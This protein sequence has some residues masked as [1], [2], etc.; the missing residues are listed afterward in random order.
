VGG[1]WLRFY[2]EVERLGK[3]PVDERKA[4]LKALAGPDS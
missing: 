3:L 2:A 4:A 1:D